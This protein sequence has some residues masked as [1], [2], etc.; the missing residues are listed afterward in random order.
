MRFVRDGYKLLHELG[1]VDGKQQLTR[2][3]R[4]LARLPVDPRLA[5]MLLAA[6]EMHCLKEVLIIASALE[7]M[8]P[9]ERPLDKAQAADEKHAL[10]RD[11]RSDFYTYIRL[12]NA[13]AEQA[14]HLS[15]NKL[16]SWC[17]THFLSFMRMREWIDV[18]RQLQAQVHA[19]GLSSNH[20]D[21]D[22]Q[23]VHCALLTGL[24]GNIAF[25]SEPGEYTG[26]RNLKFVLFPGSGLAK[27]RPKWLMAAELVETGRRYLRTAAAIEPDWVEP[28]AGD[29]V[30]R[31]YS[32][33]HW[34]QKRAQVVAYETRNPLW[35]APGT[36]PQG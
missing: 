23:A 3:G 22:Y 16:R 8:D 6:S 11:E 5:R 36:T 14:R 13:Y 10:F 32:E 7:A 34:E 28:L 27:Q 1:A 15:Q 18:H 33:P 25:Q 31:S 29:L 9:R 26:A 12:W 2:M 21:A 20:E 19:M 4:Q 17:R 35:L 24:L 30:K